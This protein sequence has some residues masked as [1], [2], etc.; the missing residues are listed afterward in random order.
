LTQQRQH[1]E[2][3]A[4]LQTISGNVYF[5]HL[6]SLHKEKYVYSLSSFVPVLHS[7]LLWRNE[8]LQ[9]S[10]VF[11]TKHPLQPKKLLSFIS[12]GCFWAN[13]MFFIFRKKSLCE[14]W[15][16]FIEKQYLLSTMSIVF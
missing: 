3:K 9:R 13:Q 4:K 14:G 6:L 12:C 11:L 15:V 5:F 16:L 8:V 10:A 2:L 7:Q 1:I